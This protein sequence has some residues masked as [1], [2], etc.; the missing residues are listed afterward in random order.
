MRPST[1]SHDTA[2]PRRSDGSEQRMQR[3]AG[4]ARTFSTGLGLMSIG[5]GL[6]ELLAP[7]RV[8]RR[9]G[10]F[11]N[12]SSRAI[13]RAF[14]VR[15]IANGVAILAS[16]RRSPWLWAR[17]GGD[18]LDLALLNRSL[19]GRSQSRPR[20]GM[21][22]AA[23]VGITALDALA[24]QRSRRSEQ[25]AGAGPDAR[26]VKAVVTIRRPVEE[27]YAYFRELSNLPR[28]MR[29]IESVEE[30][31]DG[32]THWAVRGPG[33]RMFEWD[34]EIVKERPNEILSWRSRPGGDVDTDG[35]VRFVPAPGG[36]GTEVHAKIRYH[37]PGGRV[38]AMIAKLFGREPGQ[39]AR[40][41]LRRLKQVLET[42][43]VMRSDAS[44]HEG[45]HAA[46]PPRIE[47]HTMQEMG[48]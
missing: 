15:E 42:G 14:G 2:T 41:D 25:H 34:A 13:L 9:A 3:H 37:A 11:G 17:V 7:G 10:M 23:I 27:V 44:I 30:R 4:R 46:R 28:F 22:I 43:D 21:S 33:K 31:S 29:H 26:M 16:R 5:L 20:L 36:R 19:F 1:S 6:A 48:R 45:M 12:G 47:E 32:T 24:A 40:G 8:S 35:V 39:Q 38:G 18:L